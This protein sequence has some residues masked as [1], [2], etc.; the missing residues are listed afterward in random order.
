MYT[1]YLYVLE[2]LADWEIGH[3]TA[4]LS[5]G[6][7]FR[8][9]APEVALRTA[10]RNRAPVRTM[11][12]LNVVPDCTVDEISIDASGVLLLP[13]AD[14]WG[15]ARHAAVL[16]RAEAL[17]A[18][19]GTVC[20]ICCATVALANRGLLDHRPHASNGPGFL[21]RF[22]PGYRGQAHCA[23]APSVADGNLI[24]AGCTG[25]LAWARHILDRLDVFSPATLRAWYDYFRTGAPEHFFTLMQSLPR[26]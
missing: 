6:R 15:D 8:E 1:V 11:G 25:A 14:T 24:T 20:A 22:A 17:L 10:G 2:T 12:G 19:G 26:E 5:S 16:D 4:E 3:V 13:G 23:D 7:F 18:A 9:G 21:E